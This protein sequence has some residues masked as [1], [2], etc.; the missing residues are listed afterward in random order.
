MKKSI[1]IFLLAFTV[2][3]S[4]SG[5]GVKIINPLTT[6]PSELQIERT[7]ENRK[8]AKQFSRVDIRKYG[9][10]KETLTKNDL[11][12]IQSQGPFMIE[13]KNI[14]VGEFRPAKKNLNLFD[15][16]KKFTAVSIDLYIK[17]NSDDL[18]YVYPDEGTLTANTR[19]QADSDMTLS[20]KVGGEFNHYGI[21]YGTIVYLL[22]SPPENLKSFSLSIDS[23][24]NADLDPLGDSYLF[25]IKL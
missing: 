24:N 2:C 16:N 20:G 5:C 4:L 19:E 22:K 6:D 17:N 1:S 9:E 23:P 10:Y 18:G 12:M 3:I 11:N 13:I 8:Y 21:R 15:N 25:K 14:K 7:A